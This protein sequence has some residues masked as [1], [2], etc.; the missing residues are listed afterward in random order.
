MATSRR[1]ER[2]V[3]C[4]P[5]GEGC[6]RRAAACQRTATRTAYPSRSRSSRRTCCS[7]AAAHAIATG[8]R[9]GPMIRRAESLGPTEA[10]HSGASDDPSRHADHDWRADPHSR[11]GLGSR[12][13]PDAVRWESPDRSYLRL[14]RGRHIDPGSS[15]CPSSGAGPRPLASKPARIPSGS[16]D[17]SDSKSSNEQ[18]LRDDAVGPASVPL[19]PHP[20][21]LR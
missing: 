18:P 21:K 6:L 9:A 2:A 5:C 14:R 8:G 10:S 3:G 4:S 16:T 11:I 19:A 17:A 20:R 7:F 15:A 13:D 12:S 1:A